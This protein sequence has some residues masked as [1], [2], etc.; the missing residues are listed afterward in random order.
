M[1]VT[2]DKL[3]Q[4]S[5]PEEYFFAIRSGS[6]NY[7]DITAPDYCRNAYFDHNPARLD[8]A[9]GTYC[10][11]GNNTDGWELEMYNGVNWVVVTPDTTYSLIITNDGLAALTNIR[12]GGI[13]LYFSGI[14]IIN[15]TILNPATPI[16]TWTDTTFLQAGEVVFSVGTNGAKW[17]N[18]ENGN[19]YLR[20]LLRWRFNSS[21]GGLQYI[22][23]LPPDGVGSAADDNSDNWDIGAIGLYI[24]DP[25]DNSTDILFAVATLPNIVHKHASTSKVVG[26]AIKLYFNTVLTNLGV[27]SNLQILDESSMDLPT[28]ENETLLTFPST[29]EKYAHDCYIVKDLYGTNMP[30]IA[31]KRDPNTL[32]SY[33]FA[34]ADSSFNVPDQYGASWA[35]FQ[36]A[37]NFINVP[38]VSFAEDV[39]NYDFVYWDKDAHLYKL[40]LGQRENTNPNAKMPIGIRIGNSIVFSGTIV[41]KGTS[42]QYDIEL[43]SGGAEYRR[44]DELLIPVDANLIFKV[45]VLDINSSEGIS[46]FRLVGPAVGNIAING[47]WVTMPATYDPRSQLPRYGSN[48]RFKITATPMQNTSW[49][50]DVNWLNKP[51][52]CSEDQA[53]KISGPD[54]P[55]D[56]MVGWVVAA[57]AIKLRLDLRNEATSSNYGTTRYATNDEV[58]K[59]ITNANAKNQTAITPETLKANYLQISVPDSGNSEGAAGSSLSN[60]IIVKTHVKFNELVLGKHA[61]SPYNSTSDN[62]YVT[63]SNLDFYGCAYR[64]WYQDLAEYYEADTLYEPGTLVCFG[65]LKEITIAETECDAI[66]S[67]NPGFELGDKKNDNWLPVALVGRTPV[68]FDGNCMPRK[69]DKIYLSKIKKGCASTVPN[70]KCLGRIIGNMVGSSRLIECVVRIDF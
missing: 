39:Q 28:V 17:Q 38:A 6:D 33:E 13:Q 51:V 19:P 2:R 40:A 14:K 4:Y 63:D 23:S 68:L 41:N 67:T 60:P 69:F 50:F 35:W 12:L 25:V 34:N 45:E 58:Q 52:Y 31:V 15:Q 57:N 10:A 66:I 59:I 36:P 30:A 46:N 8:N 21:S 16:I 18:D 29:L 20:K 48:A 54:D 49:N 22:L 37:D 70:G 64:A 5:I 32:N 9:R 7:T 61:K 27:V 43:I 55:T 56:S 47:G 44:G 62:P 24:K 1:I 11:I 3:V 42:Y 26:N 65:G 53:G